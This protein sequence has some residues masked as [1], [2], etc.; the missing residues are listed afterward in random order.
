MSSW[1]LRHKTALKNTDPEL[2]LCIAHIDLIWIST[3]SYH[4]QLRLPTGIFHWD[5]PSKIRASL[6]VSLMRGTPSSNLTF[7]YFTTLRTLGAERERERA[8]VKIF[9]FLRYFVLLRSK[10]TF[11]NCILEH[12]NSYKFRMSG[13]TSMNHFF[14]HPTTCTSHNA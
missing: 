9:L 14:V 5:A 7:L 6:I 12:Y 1:N 13:N 3:L 10:Y 8:C 4:I 11:E 2:Q